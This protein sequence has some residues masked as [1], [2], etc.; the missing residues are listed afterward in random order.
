MAIKK[1]I[2]MPLKT[3]L[4]PCNLGYLEIGKSK[5]GQKWSDTNPMG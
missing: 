3:G 5:G 2:W 1:F 4:V